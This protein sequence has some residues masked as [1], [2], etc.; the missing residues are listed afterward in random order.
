MILTAVALVAVNL[1]PLLSSLPTV[2]SDIV[3]VTGWSAATIGI[4]TTIPV[5][6]MGLF[7]LT[8]PTLAMRFGRKYL[9]V[10]ALVSL[11]ASAL[12]RAVESVPVL[13]FVSAFLAGVGIAFA[14]GLIPG[15][16]REQL[17]HSIG[18]AT[19]TWTAAL[20]GGAAL[21]GAL[22]VPLANWLGSWSLAL[23]VWATPAIVA[24]AFWLLTERKA[25]AHD[26]PTTI[27][28]I[29]EL[30]WRNKIAWAL[31]LNMTCNSIIYYSSLAW[32]APSYEARGWTQEN[33]GWLFG[34]FTA[35]QVVAAFV[36]AGMAVRMKHRRTLFVVA[37]GLTSVSLFAIA[38]LPDF[39]PW[40]TLLT[41]G[42]F[43]SGGFAMTLGLLSEYS[44]DSF[45]AARLT[46]MAFFITYTIAAAGPLIAGALL[47][48]FDSWSLVF[49]ILGVAALLQLL[50]VVP[51][52]RGVHV[53]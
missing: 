30:P 16:V 13:L 21:G 40:L 2:A 11:T 8:V 39:A 29:R 41:F 35:S 42:F 14:A 10:L 47:D 46:A 12:L 15:I 26:P 19:S 49:T 17:P 34:L 50:T 32:I 4:L 44:K 45:S 3:E 18:R 53:D 43:L 52:R 37:I 22:T 36:L 23:A 6:C 51:L 27:V 38:W 5:L 31:A 9:V 28:R 20:A 48:F 7:A 25:D 24:L 33:A 1:R